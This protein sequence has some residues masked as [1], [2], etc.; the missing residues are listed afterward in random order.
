ARSAKPASEG[1]PRA[2]RSFAMS[3]RGLAREGGLRIYDA[4]TGGVPRG[5]VGGGSGVIERIASGLELS[6]RAA[7]LPW[8]LGLRWAGSL[9]APGPAGMPQARRSAALALKVAGDELFL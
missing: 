3:D 7:A 9:G 2:A 8:L 1:A 4:A 5:V 6:A